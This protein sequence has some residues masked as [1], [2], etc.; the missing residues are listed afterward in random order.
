MMAFRYFSDDELDGILHAVVNAGMNTTESL[1][2]LSAGIHP[3]FRGQ[4]PDAGLPNIVLGASLH[5]LNTTEKLVGGEVPF[6]IWLRNAMNL[7]MGTTE[8]Q[9]F[10]R[11][12]DKLARS[13]SGEPDIG[14]ASTLPE[15][16]PEVQERIVHFNDMV[17]FGFLRRGHHAGLAVARVEVPRYDNG[18][19]QTVAGGK[20]NLTNGTGWL[21][22]P[23]LLVTNQHVV[24]ARPAQDQP[25]PQDFQRQAEH[26]VARFDY[27]IEGNDGIPV[28]AT[29]VEVADPN[30][31][32]AILRLESPPDDP[33]G[34]GGVRQPLVVCGEPL[35]VEADS[36]HRIP[37]NIIQHPFGD[38]KQLACRNNRVSMGDDT[39]LRYF[40]DTRSGSSGS[41]V[42]NDNW[43]VVALHRAST[44]VKGVSFQGMPVPWLNIGTQIMAIVAA[45]EASAP[46]LA[47]EI[48]DAQQAIGAVGW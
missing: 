27:E 20:P 34:D 7:S 39:T 18:E 28:T 13:S 16:K 23:D 10:R 6:Q 44:D 31:D 43:E 36:G 4:L 12:F 47:V 29:S 8:E 19:L 14:D 48:S 17:P 35:L 1:R 5:T 32:F 41:P 9:V 42:C 11:S 21:I 22:A 33:A 40:T 45:I 37:V 15:F 38:P 24:K 26:A 3:G 46:A 2:A 30:L 25:S